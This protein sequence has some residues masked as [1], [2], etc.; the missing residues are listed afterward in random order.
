[1]AADDQFLELVWTKVFEVHGYPLR[2]LV[3]VVDQ[4]ER[5][6]EAAYAVEYQAE[7]APLEAKMGCEVRIYL[8]W[9]QRADTLKRLGSSGGKRRIN[10]GH[11]KG[12]KLKK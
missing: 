1:M 6:A 7:A 9:H 2:L 12:T 4:A 8:C 10:I 3:G 11:N 5:T